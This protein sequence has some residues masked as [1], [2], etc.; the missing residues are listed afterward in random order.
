MANWEHCKSMAKPNQS[1]V[2]KSFATSPTNKLT[3]T[4]RAF[5]RKYKVQNKSN[6]SVVLSLVGTNCG[7]LNLKRESFFQ[8][9]NKFQ[10]SIITLHLDLTAYFK[11]LT[12]K[13]SL[14]KKVYLTAC[15]L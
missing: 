14:I 3:K 12:W 15:I 9:V 4:R 10:P 7:G 2:A 5:K 8:L 13:N 1:S 6:S 11:F